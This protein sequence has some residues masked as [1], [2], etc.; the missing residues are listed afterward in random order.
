MK[1]KIREALITFGGMCCMAIGVAQNFTPDG[2]KIAM[3]HF[4]QDSQ[5]SHAIVSLTVVNAETGEERYAL[6]GDLGLAPASTLKV[7]TAATAYSKLGKDY[8]YKTELRYT[9]EIRKDTLFG[10]LIIK[11]GGDPSLGSWR[12]AKTKRGVVLDAW[13]KAV[14]NAGIRY[15]HGC[16]LGDAGIFNS[17]GVPDGWQWEDIGNYYGAGSSGL[18]WHENQY[19]L[20]MKPGNKV[21]D[22]VHIIKTEP[23]VEGLQF[24]NELTTETENSGDQVYIYLAPFGKTAYVRGTAPAHHPDFKVSGSIPDPALMAARKLEQELTQKGIF[25][26]QPATTMRRLQKKGVSFR[27]QEGKTLH[28]HESPEFSKLSHWF[29]KKS[30]NLYG[31]HFLKTIDLSGTTPATTEG[32]LENLIDFWKKRGIDEE[33]LHLMDGSGLSPG[34]R[35]TTKALA[36]VLVM[37][38]NADWYLEFYENLPVIHSIRMKSGSIRGVSAFS[39]YVESV[40]GEPLAFSF[41]INNYNGRLGNLLPKIFNVLDQLKE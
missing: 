21:G 22:P 24:I 34:N 28:I 7:L 27:Y 20:L 18:T 31:E 2:L 29:L 8:S 19:D 35:I 11:G 40:Q 25:V 30:I 36:H 16:V 13:V 23:E 9:G 41:I 6:N 14:K 37:A 12:Y 32:G 4:L 39:G 33:A 15:I 10:D 1:I 17:Q 38:R 5:T 3:N 26:R